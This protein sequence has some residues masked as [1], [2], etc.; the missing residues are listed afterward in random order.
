MSIQSPKDNTEIDLIKLFKAFWRG[1][2]FILTFMFLIALITILYIQ[3][4]KPVYQAKLDL[5]PPLSSDL[6]ALNIG[7][8]YIND[9]PFFY[10]EEVYKL[11]IS[12][13]YAEVTKQKY[14]KN[15]NALPISLSLIVDHN[16]FNLNVNAHSPKIA[17]L[18]TRYVLKRARDKVEHILALAIQ[19]Q[20]EINNAD[21]KKRIKLAHAAAKKTREAQIAVLREQL[22][23]AK[24][25]FQ[26]LK[27]PFDAS[28]QRQ[29]ASRRPQIKGYIREINNL[30]ERSDDL[31]IPQ[32][33]DLEEKQARLLSFKPDFTHVTFFRK[34][35]PIVVSETYMPYKSKIF[36]VFPLLFGFLTGC[37][38]IILWNFKSLLVTQNKETLLA[39]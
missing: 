15:S 19:K 23:L 17:L 32:L 16:H 29:M 24:S 39:G 28:I 27:R 12:K 1:K 35:E 37:V 14:V 5:I 31:F 21:L 8:N 4:I 34:N 10:P 30:K 22:K 33:R 26:G 25:S 38:L 2:W 7:K 20:Y 6:A 18:T 11:F 13:L 3:K 36:I 9:L